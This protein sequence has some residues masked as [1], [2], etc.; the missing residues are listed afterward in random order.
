MGIATTVR[1]DMGRIR[2]VEA[3]KEQEAQRK[4]R[5]GVAI[6]KPRTSVTDVRN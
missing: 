4:K 2:V 3:T 5:A 6:Q 1:R